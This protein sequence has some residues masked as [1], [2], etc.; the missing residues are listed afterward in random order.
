M[1][2]L[3]S[4]TIFTFC[5]L[6]LNGSRFIDNKSSKRNVD[7]SRC[8]DERINEQIM[9]SSG[10]S[11]EFSGSTYFVAFETVSSTREKK[12][13]W[14]RASL[15]KRNGLHCNQSSWWWHNIKRTYQV[16]RNLLP[17][18]TFIGLYYDG[19]IG[20]DDIVKYFI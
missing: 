19:N 4:N 7:C 14:L 13:D 18:K 12:V 3:W 1:V 20:Q 11:K 10:S 2:E 6:Q 8:F 5:L 16:V 15:V 9:L 17:S